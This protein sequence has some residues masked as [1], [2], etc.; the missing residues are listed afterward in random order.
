MPFSP[1]LPFFFKKKKKK[2]F[3]PL[4]LWERINWRLGRCYIHYR[5]K[6][7]KAIVTMHSVDPSISVPSNILT[8]SQS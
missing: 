5:K 8:L 2:L 4:E 1:F 6:Q 7:D 3:N